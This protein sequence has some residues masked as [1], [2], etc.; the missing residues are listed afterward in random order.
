MKK[1]AIMS[2]ETF[3]FMNHQD[4]ATAMHAC[5]KMKICMSMQRF[6]RIRMRRLPQ[7]ATA[8]RSEPSATFP[9]DAR[10]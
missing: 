1:T 9:G 8:A 4:G 7:I 6:S 2:L 3:S 5:R 10:R